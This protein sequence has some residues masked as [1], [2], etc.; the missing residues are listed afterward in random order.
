MKTVSISKAREQFSAFVKLAKQGKEDVVIQNRG[1]PEAVIISFSDYE[2]LQQ[3]REN[4]RRK[5]AIQALQ[6]IADE[7]GRRNKD[8]SEEEAGKT[9]DE[10]TR[11]AIN[12]LVKKGTV[13]FQ[14]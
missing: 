3:A 1:R 2:M 10:I 7:V 11:E 5:A 13:R 6:R 4:E 8:M 14:E 9:A 12:S